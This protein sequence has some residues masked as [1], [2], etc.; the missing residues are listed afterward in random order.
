MSRSIVISTLFSGG[1]LR[2]VAYFKWLF[3]VVVL[4]GWSLIG[5][6]RSIYGDS[7]NLSGPTLSSLLLD[8]LQMLF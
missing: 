2:F 4:C 5:V 6:L 7:K 1:F 8:G 3:K